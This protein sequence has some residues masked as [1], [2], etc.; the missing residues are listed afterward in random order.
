[1]LMCAQTHGCAYVQPHTPTRPYIYTPMYTHVRTYTRT[2]R[3]FS[4]IKSA[5]QHCQTEFHHQSDTIHFCYPITVQSISIL[6]THWLRHLYKPSLSDIHYHP[7]RTISQSF[8]TISQPFNHLLLISHSLLP[9]P[10]ITNN[11]STH[12]IPSLSNVKSNSH[13]INISVCYKT[14]SIHYKSTTRFLI[15][16][17]FL[18][19]YRLLTSPTQL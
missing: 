19:L 17:S 8:P 5:I 16:D 6:A 11:P 1:M 13:P 9:I 7:F 18:I 15:Y 4:D 2:R 12:H 10:I 14:L 3:K